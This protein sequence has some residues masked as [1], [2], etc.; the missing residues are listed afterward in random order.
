MQ[1][2]TIAIDTRE[3]L[4]Y[5]F[6]IPSIRKK[7]D[8]GDYSL[9]GFENR[10]AVE[11]KT[12]DDFVNTVI[13]QRERFYR[14]LKKLSKMESSCVVVESNLRDI[15]DARYKAGVHPNAVIGA[16]TSIIVDFHVPVYFCSDRQV[17]CRF[18]QDF[19]TRY[20]RRIIECVTKEDPHQCN[21]EV[22]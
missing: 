19:L 3:Q 9:V 2:I 14:E 13:K 10:I 7:L 15:L 18:V 20:Y 21:Y 6:S 4:E 17:T 11:R 12:L 16:I 1:S 5:S 8:A 22:E